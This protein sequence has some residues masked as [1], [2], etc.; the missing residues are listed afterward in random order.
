Q[1][2]KLQKDDVLLMFTD[3]ISEAMNIKSEEFSDEKLE[4]LVLSVCGKSAEQIMNSITKEVQDFTAG[5]VQSDDITM[6]VLKVK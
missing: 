6:I 5:N 4:D 2:I 1:E 3:G